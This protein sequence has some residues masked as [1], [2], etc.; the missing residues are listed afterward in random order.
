VAELLE[1]IAKTTDPLVANVIAP[2][3]TLPEPSLFTK[4]GAET[5]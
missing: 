1:L 4:Y 5:S 2:L 3:A